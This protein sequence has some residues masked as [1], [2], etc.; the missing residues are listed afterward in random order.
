LYEFD[1]QSGWSALGYESVRHYCA[2]PGIEI[3]RATY[4]R[5]KRAYEQTVVLRQVDF[6]RVKQIDYTKV[7]LLLPKVATGKKKIDDALDDAEGMG[8]RDLREEYWGPKPD[9][10]GGPHVETTDDGDETG[11]VFGL[12][13]DEP[14]EGVV[15][16]DDDDDAG[17]TA[18]EQETDPQINYG[19]VSRQQ[20]AEALDTCRQALA[21]PSDLLRRVALEKAVVVL[22][23]LDAAPA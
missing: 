18:P 5:M 22:E 6:N 10:N 4:H 21:T 7:E 11:V 14:I 20:I 8:W 13:D 3:S 2:D 23:A 17:L 19:L 15:I 12:D 1:E 9:D 16:E